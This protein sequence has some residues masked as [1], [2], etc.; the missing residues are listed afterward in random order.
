MAVVRASAAEHTLNPAVLASRKQLEQLACGAQD[1]EVLHGW[2][3][4]LVGRQLQTL[5][6]GELGIYVR[7]GAIELST[8]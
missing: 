4:R 7:D 8:E 2:R 3:G 5:L 1:S 6:T